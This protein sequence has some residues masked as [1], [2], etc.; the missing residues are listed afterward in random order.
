MELFPKKGFDKRTQ[1]GDN[2]I[3]SLII[4]SEDTM[5]DI[6]YEY[7]E[8]SLQGFSYHADAIR[9]QRD[10]IRETRRRYVEC[11]VRVRHNLISMRRLIRDLLNGPACYSRRREKCLECWYRDA[12][13]AYGM[14]RPF[15]GT[16]FG[17]SRD[18][19]AIAQSG[20]PYGVVYRLFAARQF[21]KATDAFDDLVAFVE[22]YRGEGG[23][24][25]TR[26]QL[27]QAL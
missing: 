7:L 21:E 26:E 1:R 10:L 11:V 2:L 27:L 23:P 19:E 9:L 4:H 16:L 25:V 20:Q 14:L 17:L 18:F 3:G 13:K 24:R 8:T 5:A 6:C 22:S 12:E 15:I